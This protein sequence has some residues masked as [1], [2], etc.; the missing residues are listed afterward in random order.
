ML[1]DLCFIFLLGCLFATNPSQ[2]APC[3]GSKSAFF[4]I[5]SNETAV[6]NETS[7]YSFGNEAI[8]TNTVGNLGARTG[9]RLIVNSPQQKLL[10]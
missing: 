3:D 9:A 8:L 5:D 10:L 1:R 4:D 2:A 6:L 7:T